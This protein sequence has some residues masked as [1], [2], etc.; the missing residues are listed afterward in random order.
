MLR[1]ARGDGTEAPLRGA[2]SR[3]A[4]ARGPRIGGCATAFATTLA[5]A[6]AALPLAGPASPLLGQQIGRPGSGP[7]ELPLEAGSAA[8]AAVGDV[9][10][11]F[12][13]SPFGVAVT[14][15]GHAL[16]D[17]VFTTGSLPEP[18]SLGPYSTLFAWA[19]STDLKQWLPLGPVTPGTTTVGPVSLDKF[20]VVVTAEA[21]TSPSERTGP[22]V[23]H[24]AS[25]S[26]WLQS[27]LTH[28]LFRGVQ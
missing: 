24:G 1:G 20:L 27:F 9:R 12:A 3:Q 5:L 6:S 11:V 26:A 8:P 17:L 21:T 13:H 15:D 7:Y 14:P 10:L 16:Y 25:P 23:L 4:S 28:P 22:I 19:A 18:A 2:A